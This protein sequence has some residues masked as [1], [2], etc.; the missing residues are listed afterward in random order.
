MIIKRTINM[1]AKVF[2]IVVL[3]LNGNSV[4]AANTQ[5]DFIIDLDVT[6]IS[7]ISDGTN[8]GNS[9]SLIIPITPIV[10][11]DSDSIYGTITFDN[12]EVLV[13]ADN[14]GGFFEAGP[15]SGYE[16]IYMEFM[17]TAASVITYNTGSLEFLGVDGA[18]T[19]NPLGPTD[20]ASNYSGTFRQFFTDLVSAGGSFSFTGFNYNITL[21]NGGP[22]TIETIKFRFQSEVIQIETIQTALK[23][24]GFE[25]PFD[26]PL[27]ITKNTKRAIPAKITL[28]DVDN[29]LIT[30]SDILAP[31]VINIEFGGVVYG[32][33]VS[34]DE[35]LEPV[36]A[37]N[38][39][40]AFAFNP[41]T[42]QWEYRIGTKQF[43]TPGTYTVTVRSGNDSEYSIDT[44]NGNC[45]NTFTRQD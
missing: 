35:L 26:L 43:S 31:P 19:M 25:S 10:L 11:N 42:Q 21:E 41:D 2:V 37:S 5:K 38:E 8:M 9:W 7:N 4:N 12:S 36:G 23:C 40:N 16:N 1:L 39:G 18:L 32:D 6:Q 13:M 20:G 17:N 45:N 22:I 44:T 14:G 33:G 24:I 34:D 3:L 28:E 30:D 27:G 29:N 15:Y